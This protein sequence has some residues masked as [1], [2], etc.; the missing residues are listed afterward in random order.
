MEV[1]QGPIRTLMIVK[2]LDI[3]LDRM[4]LLLQ[5][6]KLIDYVDKK[7]L[8]EKAIIHIKDMLNFDNYMC[9][10]INKY[11]ESL[12]EEFEIFAYLPEDYDVNTVDKFKFGGVFSPSPTYLGDY[13]MSKFNRH[14]NFCIV[15]DD[16]MANSSDFYIQKEKTVF[17]YNEEIYH[18]IDNSNASEELISK[19]IWATSVSWHF[20]CVI[21]ESEEKL[22]KN[23]VAGNFSCD[24]I[25]NNMKE[26]IVGAFDGEGFIHCLKE[27]GS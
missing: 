16:V 20:L 10:C 15:F 6:K 14:Q 17:L 19:I 22:T 4:A 21:L 3:G 8:S 12:D 1:T 18:C 11:T 27:R 23:E 9:Q 2:V 7:K 25:L 24:F 5:N 13:L 26:F